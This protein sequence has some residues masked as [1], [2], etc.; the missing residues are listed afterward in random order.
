MIA[1]GG[2]RRAIRL[3]RPMQLREPVTEPLRPLGAPTRLESV[4]SALSVGLGEAGGGR[5]RTAQKPCW[6]LLP[7]SS[8]VRAP[9][10]LATW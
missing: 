3:S 5:K 1:G 4:F 2:R 7:R 9:L 10:A 6:C 8:A